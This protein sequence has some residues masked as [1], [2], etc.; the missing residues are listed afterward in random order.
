M[1]TA[2]GS[3][4]GG[5]MHPEMHTESRYCRREAV[6]EGMVR[7]VRPGKGRHAAGGQAGEEA[8]W[9]PCF[10]IRKERWRSRMLSM[11][12]GTQDGI[13]RCVGQRWYSV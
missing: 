6:V 2:R 1:L 4:K 12:R 9:S 3:E 5:P 7:S 10:S 13:A 8:V 11:V